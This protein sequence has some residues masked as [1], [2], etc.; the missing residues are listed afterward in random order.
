MKIVFRVNYVIIF[1]REIGPIYA[2]SPEE[3]KFESKS[4]EKCLRYRRQNVNVIQI[5]IFLNPQISNE[6]SD[7]NLQQTL[8]RKASLNHCWIGPSYKKNLLLE[9]EYLSLKKIPKV[10][11][12]LAIKFY[13]SSDSIM[14]FD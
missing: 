10:P 9:K 6:S 11:D 5:C 12:I 1:A 4:V 8:S 2:E 13:I 14:F 7:S 3:K